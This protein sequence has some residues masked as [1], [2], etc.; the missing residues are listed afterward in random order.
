[1]SNRAADAERLRLQL[2]LTPNDRVAW[3][4]LAA[5]EGDLGNVVAAESAARRA[6]ALGL[7]APETRLVLGRALQSLRQLD[8][9]ERAFSDAIARRPTYAEAHRDLAQ[10]VWMRT[11]RVDRALARLERA[12]RSAPTDPGLHAVRCV[13]LE[14]AGDNEAALAAAE[15]GLG[16][17]RDHKELLRLAAHL[18]AHVGR[19]EAALDYAARAAR[20]T[21]NGSLEHVTWCEALLAAGRNDE[22]ADAVAALVV[23]Q[24]DN[25]YAI[26]LQATVWRLQGDAR[27]RALA[28]YDNLVGEQLLDAPPGWASRDAFLAELALEL[29]RLHAFESHPLQQSVR[30]GSQLPL[31]TPEMTRPLIAA[32]FASIGAAVRAHLTR[33]G[34]GAGPL[35]SRNRGNIAITGAWSVRL[36]AGGYHSD[37]VHPQGW[38]SSACYIALPGGIGKGDD[39]NRAG[40]LRLGRPAIPTQPALVAEHYIRPRPGLLALFPAYMWHGVEPFDDTTPRLTV[41]FDVV[42][43]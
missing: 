30:G 20:G 3:H 37:H 28:D 29:E 24:P 16:W 26:A 41:A 27:Y 5:A 18:A 21:P 40:W 13:V 12:L 33:V 17:S 22:A 4:N 8:D 14:F 32:L 11:G 39:G 2:R 10:L 35:R 42:P 31:Q 9:A 38:L 25:Q 7:E 23:A 36:R 6:I 15:A 1:M 43:A 19:V 34:S